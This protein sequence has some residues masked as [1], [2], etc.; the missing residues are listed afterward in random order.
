MDSKVV[1][2]R[3][4]S[5]DEMD[6]RVQEYKRPKQSRKLEIISRSLAG[7]WMQLGRAQN[8]MRECH[9]CTMCSES[10]GMEM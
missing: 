4:C 1:S 3:K 5:C 10:K 7:V 8:A 6:R 9:G 2:L